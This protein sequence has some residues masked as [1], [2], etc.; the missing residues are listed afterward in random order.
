MIKLYKVEGTP[1]E[2][3]LERTGRVTIW[4]T[5]LEPAMHEWDQRSEEPAPDEVPPPSPIMAV[6]LNGDEARDW[7]FNAMGWPLDHPIP[8]LTRLQ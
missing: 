8:E 4:D 1:Y 3:E 6:A 7:V 5:R 2:L